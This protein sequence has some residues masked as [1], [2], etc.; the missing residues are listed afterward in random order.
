MQIILVSGSPRRKQ[1][2]SYLVDNFEIIPAEIDERKFE[3]LAR[4]PEELVVGLAR[5]KAKNSAKQNSSQ[6]GNSLII[7]ADTA[8]VLEKGNRR[9]VIGKP[10]D[11][12][13]A[14]K[15]LKKLRGKTHKVFTGLCFLQRRIPFQRRVGWVLTDYVVSEVTFKNFSDKT[16]E[17]Y[18]KSGKPLDK[19]GA[20]GIQEIGNK[21]VEKVEGSYTNVMGLPVER[22]GRM[23]MKIGIKVKD[24]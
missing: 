4:E 19:A 5:R 9:E 10:K 20:Y 13:E 11:E 23:L 24:G 15:M 12:K 16:M 2:L 18:I 17:K 7:A 14:R 22:L 1:L 21:F 3:K 6:K 8:V